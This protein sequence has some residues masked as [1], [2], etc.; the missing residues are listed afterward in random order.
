MWKRIPRLDV[1]T[2]RIEI[3]GG[4]KQELHKIQDVGSP[5]RLI[6]LQ[7]NVQNPAN[8]GPQG[9]LALLDPLRQEPIL[10]EPSLNLPVLHFRPL[11][12]RLSALIPHILGPS[13]RTHCWG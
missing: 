6:L 5:I 2:D 7:E 4:A 13:N 10:L 3:F 9:P 11:G 8:P 12:Q 1:S